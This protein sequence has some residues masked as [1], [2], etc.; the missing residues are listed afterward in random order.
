M[1]RWEGSH[2]STDVKKQV[3]WEASPKAF[4]QLSCEKPTPK[5][6]ENMKRKNKFFKLF[7]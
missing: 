6:N 7:A 4:T 3:D 2:S 1:N 5:I